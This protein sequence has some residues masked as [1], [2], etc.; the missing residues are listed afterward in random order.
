MVTSI[1]MCQ[2]KLLSA[3]LAALGVCYC[4]VFE[5]VVLKKWCTVS[6]A[7]VSFHRLITRMTAYYCVSVWGRHDAQGLLVSKTT[8]ALIMDA[9]RYC[10]FL[11]IVI[12]TYFVLQPVD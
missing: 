5:R 11:I 9:S 12:L 2:W 4:L 3:E 7:F 1:R 8:M 10:L 6:F